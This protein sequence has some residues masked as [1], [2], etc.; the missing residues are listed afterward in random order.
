[1]KWMRLI[2]PTGPVYAPN[3]ITCP[4]TQSSCNTYLSRT[5][6]QRRCDCKLLESDTWIA[7]GRIR[8]RH[9]DTRKP[10]HQKKEARFHSKHL[11]YFSYSSSTPPDLLRVFILLRAW[12]S[13]HVIWVVDRIQSGMLATKWFGRWLNKFVYFRTIFW[14]FGRVC[15]K[16]QTNTE[17]H[18]KKFPLI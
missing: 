16:W 15:D 4:S 6:F 5:E 8:I 10:D 1:M 13:G 11:N 17:V 14:L 9:L 12:L 18:R 7:D 3:S 2:S